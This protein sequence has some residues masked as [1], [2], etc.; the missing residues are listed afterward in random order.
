MPVTL[1]PTDYDSWLNPS[2]RDTNSAL[3]L[4]VPYSGSMR[5]YPVSTRLNQ[6]QN[7][8]AECAKPVELEPAP[9]G[10]LFA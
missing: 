10:Q 9:R 3:Q 5:R 1:R 2:A 4:L 7:D 8:D 6:V